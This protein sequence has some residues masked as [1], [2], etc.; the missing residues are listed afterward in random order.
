MVH[1]RSAVM[2]F[3]LPEGAG[4]SFVRA[5]M[6]VIATMLLAVEGNA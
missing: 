5:V 6:L 1:R 3:A 2:A 4:I